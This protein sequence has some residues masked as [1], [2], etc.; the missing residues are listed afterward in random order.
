LGDIKRSIAS[1][2]QNGIRKSKEGKQPFSFELYNGI[3]EQ[4]LIEGTFLVLL[5]PLS[6]GIWL[7]EQIILRK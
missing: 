2:R 6:L 1:E 4:F 3:C 7:A 5:I